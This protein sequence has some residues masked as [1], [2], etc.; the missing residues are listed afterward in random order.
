MTEIDD[1]ILE[2]PDRIA[3]CVKCA[4]VDA[5][6]ATCAAFPSGIPWEILMGQDDHR[7]PFPGDNGI[8]F[9]PPKK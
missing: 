8:R 9:E 1:R 4:H 5:T 6:M 7:K 3:P 2:P